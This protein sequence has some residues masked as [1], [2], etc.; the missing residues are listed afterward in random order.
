MD[1]IHQ[2]SSVLEAYDVIKTDALATRRENQSLRNDQDAAY[3]RSLEVDREKMA[4]KKLQQEIPTEI[5]R[6]H[7]TQEDDPELARLLTRLSLTIPREPEA[8]S[9]SSVVLS[10]QF[11]GKQRVNR[12]FALT[13][14]VQVNLSII[15]CQHVLRRMSTTFLASTLSSIQTALS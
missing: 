8:G 3:K 15:P 14:S 1:S 13:D 11:L 9:K 5:L 6:Q 7:T 4:Q 2:V 10:V 12:R